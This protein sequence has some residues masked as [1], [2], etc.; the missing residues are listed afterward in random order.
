MPWSRSPS[1]TASATTELSSTTSTLMASMVTHCRLH[2]DNKRAPLDGVIPVSSG[3]SYRRPMNQIDGRRVALSV[4]LLA[5]ITLL[6]TACTGGSTGA[7]VAT[8]SATA[9]SVNSAADSPSA[10]ATGNGALA[11]A[12]CMR[13]HGL[14][15]F[16]DPT[17]GGVF[18]KSKLQQ[19]GY[20]TSQLRAVQDGPCKTL[21]PTASP[22]PAQTIS[23]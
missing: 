14:P 19:M 8:L 11:F 18:D 20:S 15:N 2:R 5:A 9:T 21:L 1:A 12:R 13:A 16:P 3:R 23:V 22:S 4:A 17:G 10:S 7:S 6:A